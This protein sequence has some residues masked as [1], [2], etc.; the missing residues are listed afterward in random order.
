[1]VCHMIYNTFHVCRVWMNK[2]QLQATTPEHTYMIH[3]CIM[4]TVYTYIHTCKPLP[5]GCTTH[6]WHPFGARWFVGLQVVV[7]SCYHSPVSSNTVALWT[8]PRQLYYAFVFFLHQ[9]FSLCYSMAMIHD[10][11]SCS[12]S[13][14]P[15]TQSVVSYWQCGHSFL[16]IQCVPTQSNSL[17]SPWCVRCISQRD[18]PKHILEHFN[19]W[20]TCGNAKASLP[21]AR[22]HHVWGLGGQPLAG[23]YS[24]MSGAEY[25]DLHPSLTLPWPSEPQVNPKWTPSQPQ[26]SP[27]WA[28]KWEPVGTNGN[29]PLTLRVCLHNLTSTF[30]NKHLL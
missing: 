12:V 21:L 20:A 4:F 23:Y 29:W 13:L 26:V 7:V 10:A 8:D 3:T 16:N 19:I 17:F 5:T 15:V 1:M 30:K 25:Y 6:H 14:S 28:P 27:K 18:A 2:L 11:L 9:T 22:E 24:V